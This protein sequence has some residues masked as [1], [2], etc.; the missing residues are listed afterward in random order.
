[1]E[2]S[3]KLNV[4][5]IFGG[6]S[7]EHDVSLI[8]ASNTISHFNPKRYHLELLY[9]TRDGHWLLCDLSSFK[10]NCDVAKEIAQTLTGVPVTLPLGQGDN[11]PLYVK[12][13]GQSIPIDVVFTVL[14][15]KNGCGAIMQGI[16]N[17]VNIPSAGPSLLGGTVG[18]DKD[19][20]KRLLAEA[21]LPV[22]RY[23]VI[24]HR[25]Y[26]PQCIEQLKEQFDFPFFIKPANSGSSIGVHKIYP[27]SDL[28]AA[29]RDV[30]SFDDKLIVEEYIDG[31]EL[32]IY[33]F[34]SDNEIKT[35]IVRQTI[36]GDIHDFYTYKAKYGSDNADTNIKNIPA[37]I[38]K[39]EHERVKQLTIDAYK[40]LEGRGEIR[41]DLFYSSQK[42]IYINEI[43]TL[44]ALMSKK[45]QPSLWQGCGISEPDIVDAL[46][47]S[48]L[49]ERNAQVAR[50]HNQPE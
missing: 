21:N 30:F 6:R 4:L 23:T 22:C 19:V 2:K 3:N 5:L 40:V 47:E 42:K 37:D 44:P 7:R 33:A 38:S 41:L 18:Y 50:H 49:E 32:E 13:T 15:G 31:S 43:N 17:S 28:E 9:I 16:W 36:V 10:I 25:E 1:M 26:T 14:Q 29:I 24:H 12:E 34:R 8:S 39:E 20:T 35:S 46:I 45:S 48:A 27:E 11:P